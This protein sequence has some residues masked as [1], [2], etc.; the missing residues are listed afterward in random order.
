MISNFK[1]FEAQ[2]KK[3]NKLVQQILYF[4]YLCIRTNLEKLT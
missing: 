3:L 2:V 1:Y 4:I